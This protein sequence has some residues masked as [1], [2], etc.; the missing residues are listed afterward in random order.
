MNVGSMRNAV[1]SDSLM[2]L[3]DEHLH[4]RTFG[5]GWDI[6]DDAPI[7]QTTDN[8]GRLVWKLTI[9]CTC[10]ARRIDEINQ[11]TY[12]I[13]NRRYDYPDGYQM[14]VTTSRVEAR[15]EWVARKINKTKK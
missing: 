5:H 13:D 14:T 7:I 9:E 12:E 3:R 4:C 15:L 6:A 1:K 8:R 2:D 10:G 11:K